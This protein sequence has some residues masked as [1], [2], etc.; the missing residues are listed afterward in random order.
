MLE[1]VFSYTL[2]VDNKKAGT[3]S[4]YSKLWG[5]DRKKVRRFVQ[6]MGTPSGHFRDRDGT[7]KGHDIYIKI[8]NL[9]DQKD[10]NG[11]GK[12]HQRDRDGDTT[13]N[14]NPKPNPKKN[15]NIYV[16]FSDLNIEAWQEWRAYKR[17]IRDDYKTE[18]GEKAKIEN[19]IKISKG[20]KA[21]Q[22]ELIEHAITEEWK[23]IYIPKANS[24]GGKNGKHTGLGEKD[25]RKGVGEDGTF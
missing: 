4:G 7:G 15:K 16:N 12:G 25:Y 8:N 6:E 11:T 18:K 2:D 1:A 17:K 10:T 21:Y 20:D 19:L 14:P 5:W 24:K 9:Q 23:G 22:A 13:I 3:I